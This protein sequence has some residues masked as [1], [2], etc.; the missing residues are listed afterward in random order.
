[1]RVLVFCLFLVLGAVSAVADRPPNFVV[2][3][4]DDLG[5]GD[6]SC[7]GAKKIDT[8]RLDR[9]AAEGIR[10][11][12]FY[13]C[14]DVCTPSR[15]GLLT[16][17]YPI[18]SGMTPVLFPNSVIGLPA[19][20]VTIAEL[21]KDQGYATACVGKWHLGHLPP[22]LPTAHG[23]DQYYGI[24]YSND[25]DKHNPPLMRDTE[26]IE[27]PVDQT[28][29]TKRY[30]EEAVRFI[31][32]N[33]E[34][35]F[36]LYMPHT[37]THV[38]LFASDDFLGTS[39]GG[40]YGDVVEEI[41]WSVGQVL[42]AIKTAGVDE[43]TLVIFTSD[44]GPWLKYGDHGGSAGPLRDGKGTT[45]EGGL[46]VPG[47]A[48]WPGTI[49]AGRREDGLAITLDLLP[50]F[51]ELAGATLPEDRIMDGRSIAGV[52]RGD[53]ERDGDVMAYFHY[54][55][56]FA[57]R[58]GPWKLKRPVKRSVYGKKL[59]HETLLFNLKDDVGEQNNLADAHPE[60]VARL[61]AAMIEF[62]KTAVPEPHA[63]LP[64]KQNKG[65]H[66]K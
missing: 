4:A 16:G 51:A 23:F 2:I 45:F 30:T 58:E 18:R 9:M 26:I 39:E 25:M 64:G 10:F 21:L 42:D 41:D 35:P 27:N 3:F 62:E 22:F 63:A 37:F 43:H 13:S 8:P 47:I 53:G 36:F 66:K 61:E 50:T 57:Y 24:P 1:M 19:E 46:R 55:K 6:L 11:T 31:E 32:A 7:F 20:E 34:Q 40:L 54:N 60:I 15:A 5:Y 48:R 52:L 49:E 29:V 17:R 59:E 12:S 38:P 56:L 33:A 65:A 44:N 28:T 14:A